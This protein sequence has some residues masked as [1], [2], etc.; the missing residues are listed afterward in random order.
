MRR[1]RS[2]LAAREFVG[3]K[4]TAEGAARAVKNNLQTPASAAPEE[5]ER[6]VLDALGRNDEFRAFALPA[7]LQLPTFV[8]YL[9]GM[10]YGTHLD[11]SVMGPPDDPIRTDLSLT[12]FL[13]E[14]D[15]YDGG[16]LVMELPLG[17]QEVKLLSGEA[18]IYPS[19]TLHRVNPVTRG[20]RLV[21][22]SAV[23]MDGEQSIR[24]TATHLPDLPEFAAADVK[25]ERLTAADPALAPALE[26]H[27]RQ[28]VLDTLDAA[29]D[30]P[31]APEVVER[32]FEK[33]QSA[34]TALLAELGPDRSEAERE[35]RIIAE[36]RVRL[37][38]V[39]AELA[40]RLGLPR[41]GGPRGIEDG[42]IAWILANA[43]VS[44]RPA[45]EEE[46][47]DLA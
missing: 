8:R 38:A 36:R 18:V 33:I 35:M 28:Q 47:A 6:I 45:T 12:L 29:F 37:G 46:L 40:R 3:G 15:A 25:V 13:N 1:I 7:R 39:L 42:V 4:L 26:T 10:E 32:E 17:E 20:E 16:E 34:A 21:A 30:F 44:V 43:Q 23:E 9:P 19:T 24:L 11:N 31:V 22:I 2:L 41:D 27:L 5:C 14:P